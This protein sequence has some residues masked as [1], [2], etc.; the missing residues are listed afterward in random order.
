MYLFSDC[1][2]CGFYLFFNNQ[3]KKANL[4]VGQFNMSVS[5][6]SRCILWN[7]VNENFFP[8]INYPAVTLS[9][10]LPSLKSLE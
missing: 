3:T 9:V 8:P 2:V 6:I 1:S 10:L 5:K 7:L 4:S